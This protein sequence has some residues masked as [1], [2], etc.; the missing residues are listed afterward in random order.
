MSV[1]CCI[2]HHATTP[3][4]HLSAASV[5]GPLTVLRARVSEPADGPGGNLRVALSASILI[6]PN[7]GKIEVLLR[8]Q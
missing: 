8:R 4:A 5:Y 7:V 1:P 6:S 2:F 3:A